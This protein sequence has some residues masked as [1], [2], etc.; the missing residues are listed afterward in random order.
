MSRTGITFASLLAVLFLPAV[1]AAEV[2]ITP[3]NPPDLT[4]SVAAGAAS[5]PDGTTVKFEAAQVKFDPPDIRVLAFYA[6]AP[7]NFASWYEIWDPWPSREANSGAANTIDLKPHRGGDPESDSSRDANLEAAVDEEGTLILGLL[8]RQVIADSVIVTSADGNKTFRMNADYKYNAEWGQIANL[9]G[10]LGEEFKAG[11][12]VSCKYATQRL[13]LVQVGAGGELRVKKGAPRLVCPELPAPDSGCVGLAGIYIAG[14][15][16][17]DNPNY[18]AVG[19]LKAGSTYAIT[20]YEIFPIQPA[21][22]VAPINKGA[23][24]RSVQKLADGGELK[25]A[26]MGASVTVGAEAPAWWAD[27]WTEKNLGFPSRVVVELR[28]RFPQAKVTP[29]AAFQGGTQTKYGLEVMDKTV[30]PAKA[31]LVLIDFGGNDVSGPIGGKPN[32]PP[33][34]FKEDMRAIVKKA[35]AAGMEVLIIVGE[36]SNPW[37]KP[38]LFERWTAYRQAMLDVA[39][40]ENVAAADIWTDF[41]NQA[42]RGIPPFSQLH[43]WLNHPGKNGHKIYADVILRCFE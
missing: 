22:P 34:Q 16:A 28:K 13:D 26:F 38:N 20:P 3:A 35:R 6:K 2:K 15:I 39:K 8:F 41:V 1:S 31:D 12:R 5:L 17:A 10:G 29:I 7:R 33:E 14:W 23:L 36:H 21:P 11:L 32:N 37:L 30:I 40:E 19:G 27:L 25:I 24:A 43:N 42:S 4:V 18:D 9:K